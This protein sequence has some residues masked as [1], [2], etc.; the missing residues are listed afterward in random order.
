MK[1]KISLLFVVFLING[2]LLMGCSD[3]VEDEKVDEKVKE[4]KGE[5][6]VVE[7]HVGRELEFEAAVNEIVSLMPSATEIIF[8]LDLEEKLIGVTDY[9]DYPG[10]AMEKPSMG[11]FADPDIE[12]VV[13]LE[14][15][16]VIVSSLN[17]NKVERLGEMG[18]ESMVLT[19]QTIEE[20]YD[21]ID[22]IGAL[23][24]G[25]DE[26]KSLIQEMEERIGKVEEKVAEV[27]EDEK[28]GVYYELYAETLTTVGTDS[29]IHEII[30][31]AGGNNIFSDI[32]DEYPQVSEE[33]VVERNPEV[34]LFPEAHGTEEH[35]AER[36]KERPAWE[37]ISAVKNG[38]LHAVDVDIF[39]N[40]GPRVVKAIEKGAELF[41]PEVF[42]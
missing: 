21:S 34:I 17:Q 22:L 16:L 28:V 29:V 31:R 12:K 19:P 40:P 6:I 37:E 1:K 4:E 38:R 14:P 42:E 20:I 15:D 8:S 5:K 27:T 26:A 24:G 11:G 18:I 30:G 36:F 41:Y 39:S 35:A 3:N 9:C 7:D 32:D 2:F 10:Q 13:A 25:E 33:N 23:A